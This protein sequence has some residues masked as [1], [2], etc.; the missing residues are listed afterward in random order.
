MQKQL[1]D[2]LILRSLSEAHPQDVERLP[3]FY[4]DIFADDEAEHVQILA[5][6]HD[7][8]S[9]QHPTMTLD[10]IWVV[11]DPAHDERIVSA[12]LMVPQ[13]WHYEDV[14]IAV[15]RPELV[16]TLPEYRRRGLVRALMTAAHERSDALGHTVTAITGIGHYYRQF[17]YAMAVDLGVTSSVSLDQFPPR[18]EGQTPEFTL[19]PATEA[20]IPDLLAWDAFSAR[21]TTLLSLRRDAAIWRYELAGRRADSRVAQTF[22]VIVNAA[23]QGVGYVILAPQPLRGLIICAGWV[24]GEASSYAA[25]FPDV[26]RALGTRAASFDPAPHM[27]GFDSGIHPALKT[28]ITR[29]P[30]GRVHPRPYAWY[31]R[32][33]DMAAF[34]RQIAPVLER[35]LVGSGAHGYSGSLTVSFFD[36]TGVRLTFERGRLANVENVT[37]LYEQSADAGFPWHTFLNVVFGHRSYEQ[38]QAVLP[39]TYCTAQ[40]HVLLDA[41]FPLK[42]SWVLTFA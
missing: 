16:A 4:A 27:V 3:R 21:T 6:T 31:V 36:Q 32:V 25:T 39:E 30:T 29:T 14:E 23:G 1:S 11:V 40:A 5:W 42:P 7:L 13:V 8:T 28:M 26:M 18:P 24:V 20:D 33:P 12:T 17:G 2:G 34:L 35:R 19:R 38:L 22:H 9:G 37:G 41:L 10:D 15:G